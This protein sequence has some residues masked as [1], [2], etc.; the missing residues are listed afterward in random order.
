MRTPLTD[1]LFS[2]R[3]FVKS[4]GAAAM[5][6]S[7]PL[8][9]ASRVAASDR[10]AVGVIGWGMQGPNNTKGFM[11]QADCQVVAA[12]EIDPK[13][14]DAAVGAINE[15]YGNTDCKRYRDF[16]E[17]IA[18]DD[19]DA[20]M[21]AIP[22]QWHAIVATEAAKRK[23]DIYG[24]KPLA[25]TI[26]EQQAIVRAV[27][28]NKIIWQ[29]GSW[30]R[31]VPSFHKAAEIVRNG[32]IGNVTHVEVGLPGGHH[33]FPG[34]LPALDKRLASLG[35]K[36]D[37]KLPGPAEI[38]PGT[39]AWD[40]AVTP[41]PEGFDYETWIGPS[42]MEPYIDVR[43]YQNWRW[44]YNTGGG[45]LLDWIGHHGDIAHWGLGFD[46]S[47][48]SEVEAFGEAPPVNAVWNTATKYTVNCVY[49]KDVTGYAND[50]H[51]TIAG[52]SGAISMGTKWIGTDGWVWVDRSGFDASNPDWAKGDSLAENLRKVKLYEST[53]HQRNFLD[54]VKS[55]KP[56]ITPVEVGH[57][58]T[59][60]G[61]LGLISMLVGRK[62]QWDVKNEQILNDPE[63]TALLSRPYRGPWKLV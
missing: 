35:P 41:P 54:C 22:D 24:E 29:T 42:K 34:T 23:K 27:Q 11:A 60:P 58:S 45:Q 21:I 4:A 8:V 28:Q 26:A 57:H 37:G 36:P 48:P 7:S 16:R 12:C 46:V 59:I 13:K 44:N 47:G 18:R 63:A 38:V 62:L 30:Q 49:R 61:H 53:Q 9:R 32:L 19:I 55:R 3:S 15:H 56:T 25:K 17:M 50:V 52:G 39:P 31:S 14:M 20:I 1:S 51:L 10:I 43:V 5:V 40:L 6:A 33:D 2:R